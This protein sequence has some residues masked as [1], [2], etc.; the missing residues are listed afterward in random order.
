MK[1]YEEELVSMLSYLT[2]EE[3]VVEDEE[4]GF[5]VIAIELSVLREARALLKR[6][7]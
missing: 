2:N 1:R 3:G 6:R 7:K 5:A 4:S